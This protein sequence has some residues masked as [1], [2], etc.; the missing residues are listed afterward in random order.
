VV[1]SRNILKF[2]C[3][4]LVPLAALLAGTSQTNA[5]PAIQ[6]LSPS[7][8]I[9]LTGDVGTAPSI[10]RTL[11][12]HLSED[13]RTV[14]LDWTDLVDSDR[15][16]TIDRS[17][18][19]VQKGDLPAQNIELKTDPVQIKISV[20]ELRQPGIFRGKLSVHQADPQKLP[21]ATPLVIPIT[22][23]VRYPATTPV[24]PMP[25][26]VVVP[27]T[28]GWSWFLPLSGH[29][30]AIHDSP[31][32]FR[33][34]FPRLNILTAEVTSLRGTQSGAEFPRN[35]CSGGGGPCVNVRI[36]KE[37]AFLDIDASTADADRYT[38]NLSVVLQGLDRI[39]DVPLDITVRADPLWALL[40]ILAGVLLGRLGKFLND[41][42]RKIADARR[43]LALLRARIESFSAADGKL[44]KTALDSLEEKF[45]ERNFAAFDTEIVRAATW[46][47]LLDRL[48]QLETLAQAS[49]NPQVEQS[50]LNIR[51]RIGSDQNTAQLSADIEKQAAILFLG[52]PAARAASPQGATVITQLLMREAPRAR[53][54]P[55]FERLRLQSEFVVLVLI[56]LASFLTIVILAFVGFEAIYIKSTSAFGANPVSDFLTALIWGLSVD[57]AG[58][59]LSNVRG[60]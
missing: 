53:K 19:H 35:G 31:V 1:Q 37:R 48:I 16:L 52:A 42:G 55:L 29:P 26:S 9:E 17:Q 36:E 33:G 4:M 15:H 44:F 22:L 45:L 20:T 7:Q 18:V 3:A 47:D 10:A 6:L 8:G 50:L 60:G 24:T 23:T 56:P 28:N 13:Q 5:D 40:S 41:Q 57:V 11:G 46:V 25:P 39:I 14:A 43:R 38:G 54:N 12:L 30:G 27:L 21:L 32:D 49:N 34:I 2:L 59:T 51:S 58:R